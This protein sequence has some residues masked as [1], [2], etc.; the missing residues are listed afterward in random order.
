MTRVWITSFLAVAV[1]VG[2]ILLFTR[3]E[4]PAKAS[5]SDGAPVLRQTITAN[6]V[7]QYLEVYPKVDAIT[8]AAIQSGDPT[9]AN[10][11]EEVA[12][13]LNAHSLS[14]ETW[15]SLYK[16]VEDAVNAI[17]AEK[18][19][20]KRLGEIQTRIAAK[21]L[22]L[23]DAEGNFKEQLE[24]DIAALE[25]VRDRKLRGLNDVDREV[26]MRYWAQLNEIAPLPR[27]MNPNR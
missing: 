4:Q 18:N 23:T 15:E 26:V 6:D 3:D 1:I 14:F 22:A 25:A 7:L 27:P 11:R 19:N 17:R 2:G 12:V 9:R 13:V 24:K 16:R 8:L 21:Q 10:I 5:G 20:P